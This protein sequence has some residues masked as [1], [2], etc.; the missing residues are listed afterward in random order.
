[1]SNI[2]FPSFAGITW[3]VPRRQTWKTLVNEAESG[4]ETRVALR[5]M[6]LYEWDIPFGAL[7]PAELGTFWGFYAA[8]NGSY[9]PF[10][11]NDKT[12]NFAQGQTL[13]TG[14]GSNQVFNFMRSVGGLWVENRADIQSSPPPKIYLNGVL[15]TTGYTISY[16]QSGT[17]SFNSAPG[18]GVQVTADYYFYWR[19]KF[20][21]D[22]AE[23][24]YENLTTATAKKVT[25]AQ[26]RA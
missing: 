15:Q 7:L 14:N 5:S 23:L 9:D 2:A 1:M 3:P 12:D 19:V 26:V 18:N 25:L 13:G 21:D 22:I 24:E 8:R 20:K 10:L 11:L 6:P 16:L 4:Y 17:V